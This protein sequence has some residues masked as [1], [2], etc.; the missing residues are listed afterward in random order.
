MSLPTRTAVLQLYRDLLR[1][2]R[3]LEFTDKEFYFLRIRAEFQANKE[4]R[5][6]EDIAREIKVRFIYSV[7]IPSF[8]SLKITLNS[9]PDSSS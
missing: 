5:S 4:L 7:Y 3:K 2:G 1:Y 6:A 8:I 9:R